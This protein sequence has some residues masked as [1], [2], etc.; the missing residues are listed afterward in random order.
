MGKVMRFETTT[1]TSTDPYQMVRDMDLDM[2]KQ[3]PEYRLHGGG[4]REVEIVSN[5]K[6]IKRWECWVE[7]WTK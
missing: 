4:F 6:T 3:H 2:K 5:G 7:G 1:P